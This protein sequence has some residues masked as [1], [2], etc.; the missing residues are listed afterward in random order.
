MFRNTY[1]FYELNNE[2]KFCC[3]LYVIEHNTIYYRVYYS[4]IIY[5]GKNELNMIEK[6]LIMTILLKINDAIV[7]H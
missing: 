1:A 3:V 4:Y 5:H 2:E 7:N 6:S